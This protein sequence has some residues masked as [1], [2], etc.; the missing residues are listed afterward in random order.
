VLA[1]EHPFLVDNS[2]LVLRDDD[3]SEENAQDR[4]MQEQNEHKRDD[5]SVPDQQVN[6]CR[7]HTEILLVLWTHHHSAKTGEPPASTELEWRKRTFSGGPREEPI[8]PQP[9]SGLPKAYTSAVNQI[10]G[11]G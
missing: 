6:H 9:P 11:S 1:E 3:R 4:L 2:D 7:I 10:L 5:P 8:L